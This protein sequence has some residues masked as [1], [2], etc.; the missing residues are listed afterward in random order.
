MVK[1]RISMLASVVSHM[2][3]HSVWQHSGVTQRHGFELTVDACGYPNA[4]GQV[5]PMSGRAELLLG[6]TYDF[7]SG[8]H[9][10]TYVLRA[11]GDKRLVY[12]AQAQNDWDDRVIV[13]PEIHSPKD[14]EGKRF[15][16]RKPEPL[17][18]GQPGARVPS[19]RR[20]PDEGRARDP[21]RRQDA[22]LTEG[23]RAGGAGRGGRSARGRAVR[24]AGRTPGDASP[25]D[26]QPAGHP[27]RDDLRQPRMGP[28]G[29]GNDPRL[30]PVDGR[31]DPLLQDKAERDARHPRGALR[32]DH[33]RASRTRWSTPARSGRRS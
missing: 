5:V 33:R 2:P 18:P 28:R 11:K 6:G 31:R 29:R 13:R 12:L 14:L 1:P 4:D 25:G 22:S 16:I 8:L 17:R 7:V 27:Q 3:L 10:E 24:P 9:H 20:G 21:G 26:L 19:C 23:R 32:A 15:A 30:P